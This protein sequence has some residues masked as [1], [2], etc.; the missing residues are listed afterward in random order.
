MTEKPQEN[1][2]KNPENKEIKNL[3]VRIEKLKRH[4]EK[5]KHDYKTKR[6]LLTIEARL[7]KFKNY[8]KGK[9]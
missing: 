4:M 5:N 1:K 7:N 6:T 8:K 3:E 2:E 9:K